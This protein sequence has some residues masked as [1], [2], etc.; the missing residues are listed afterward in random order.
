MASYG[1]YSSQVSQLGCC[2]YILG[3]APDLPADDDGAAA[4]AA[5]LLRT[6]VHCNQPVVNEFR[7]CATHPVLPQQVRKTYNRHDLHRK[8][9]AITATQHIARHNLAP[10]VVTFALHRMAHLRRT[11]RNKWITARVPAM[12]FLT[13]LA[14]PTPIST[15]NVGNHLSSG[16]DFPRGQ[17][18]VPRRCNLY[19]P[20]SYKG[21]IARPFNAA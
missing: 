5:A 18:S 12:D 4:A 13:F 21:G 14:S 9:E 6:V 7:T 3:P 17:E 16:D 1:S 10:T 15:V 8:D 19:G 2:F 11:Q 20:E